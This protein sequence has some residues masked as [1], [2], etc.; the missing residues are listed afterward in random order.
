[1][2]T[3]ER[4]EVVGLCLLIVLDFGANS[5][6]VGN[7]EKEERDDHAHG[8]SSHERLSTIRSGQQQQDADHSKHNPQQVE[9]TL[10]YDTS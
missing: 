8:G 3:D 1:M 4:R 9:N 6:P 7:E 2:R 10:H 5:Q